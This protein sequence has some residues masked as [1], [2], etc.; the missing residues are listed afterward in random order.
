MTIYLHEQ[1]LPNHVTFDGDVA[2]DAEMM[3]L[4]LFRD[5]LCLIQ[6]SDGKG[7]QHLVR[8]HAGQTEAPR[9]KSILEDPKVTKIFHYARKD[10]VTMKV[11]LDI[12]CGPIYCTK[13]ASRLIRTYTDKHSYKTLV[14]EFLN[15]DIIKE[16]QLTNWGADTLTDAQKEYA[17]GDVLYLHHLRDCLNDMLAREGRMELAQAC[18]DFLPV[19]AALDVAGWEDIDIFAHH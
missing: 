19:R 8:I 14:K 18:F 7:D 1:D 3:G 4:N 6:L 15:I 12:S 13:T 11:W 2:V 9:L 10:V 16:E 5:R 17:A